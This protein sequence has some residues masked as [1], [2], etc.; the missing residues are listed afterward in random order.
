MPKNS[1]TTRSLFITAILILGIASCIVPV[2]AENAWFEIKSS[3]TAAYACLDH[4]NC[5]D[6]PVTFAVEPNSY[7][8]V[9]VYKEGYQMSVQ[10]VYASGAGVTTPIMVSLLP[11]SQHFGSLNISSVPTD[12]GIWIDQS[13][14]GKTPQVIGGLSEGNHAL[15]LKKAGYYDLTQGVVITAGQVTKTTLNLVSFPAQ[16]G[17]GSLRIDSTPG[18]AAIYLNNNY[19]GSTM[20]KGESFDI[21]QLTPGI[22]VLKM[23]LPNYQTYTTTND[24]REG[25][26][27]DIHAVMVPSTPGPT[28]AVKG[29]ITFR[30]NPSGANIYLD[31]A[32]RGLTP[33]TL[34]DISSGNHAVILKMSGYQDWLLSVNVPAGNIIEVSGTLMANP[35]Q[36][37]TASVT[38]LAPQPTQS[39]VSIISI[40][41]SIGICGAAAVMYRKRD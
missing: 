8:S 39:P 15:T 3:P 33:L 2:S 34:T 40:I 23:T 28:P 18:G 10:T 20:A 13:Y 5:Q 37:P 19:Q 26:V 41:A 30:S 21:N 7:H 1:I 9:T 14:Y 29:D 32:Y 31:N 24:V 36:S 17:F 6:T 25:M 12:T 22:Y 38:Q 27:Y 4:W 11:N 16:P 35:T